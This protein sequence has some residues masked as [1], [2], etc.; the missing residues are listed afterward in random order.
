MDIQMK[1]LIALS[2][3]LLGFIYNAHAQQSLGVEIGSFTALNYSYK[4][5]SH[6]GV[7]ARLGLEF[8]NLLNPKQGMSPA[9]SLLPKYNLSSGAKSDYYQ[10][11]AYVGLN[12]F[13]RVPQ[14]KLLEADPKPSLD[15]SDPRV[16][17]GFAPTFGWT[18]PLKEKSYLYAS[19]GIGF[20]WDQ[21]RFY[22]G[23][24]YWK[25]TMSQAKIPL[26][27]NAGYSI[28]F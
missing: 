6:L 11:G 22:N 25:T 2:F 8:D 15:Y 18:F 19:L 14:W 1:R 9:F 26:L 3:L 24:T 23:S 12:L 17:I 7:D 27:L 4:L 16:S 28:R 5:T 21:Y 10:D 13:V 20:I